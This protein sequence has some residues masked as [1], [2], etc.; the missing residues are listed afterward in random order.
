MKVNRDTQVFDYLVY[1]IGKLKFFDEIK[2]YGFIV[3]DED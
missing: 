1:K 3:M 2:N